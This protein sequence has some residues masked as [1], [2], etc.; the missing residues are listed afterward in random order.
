MHWPTLVLIDAI[1]PDLDRNARTALALL[2]SLL[3]AYAT[4]QL[5]ERPLDRL[6]QQRFA[7]RAGAGDSRRGPGLPEAATPGYEG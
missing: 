6:R 5:I 7:A 4:A 1:S 3:L 2:A